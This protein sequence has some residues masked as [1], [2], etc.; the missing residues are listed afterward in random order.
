MHLLVNIDVP[1]LEDAIRFYCAGLGLQLRRRLFA[2]TVADL[3][4]A[5]CPG[6]LLQKRAG[7]PIGPQSRVGRDYSRHWTP[8]H[9]DFAVPALAPAVERA[10]DAGA[11]LEA[12]IAAYAWGS[13]ALMSDPYGNGFCLLEWRNGGYDAVESA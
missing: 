2:A 13:Q 4:G 11:R 9:L 6:L 5:A 12:P 7:A 10:V 3:D 1:D 8:V